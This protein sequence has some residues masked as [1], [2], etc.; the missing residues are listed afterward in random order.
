MDPDDPCVR[1]PTVVALDHQ[2]RMRAGV[3][4]ADL[5]RGEPAISFR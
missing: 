1:P 5:V 4:D 2:H 3:L